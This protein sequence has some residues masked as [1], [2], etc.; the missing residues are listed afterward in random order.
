MTEFL[1]IVSAGGA[2]RVSQVRDYATGLRLADEALDAGA[3][4]CAIATVL[5]TIRRREPQR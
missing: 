5:A 2:P 4:K 1:L 3:E